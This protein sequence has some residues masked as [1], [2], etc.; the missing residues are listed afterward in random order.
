MLYN[1]GFGLRH[2]H[3][4][5]DPLCLMYYPMRRKRDWWSIV[6]LLRPTPIAVFCESYQTLV[7]NLYYIMLSM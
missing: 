4:L 3:A 7:N 5:A 6:L 2:R 1:E